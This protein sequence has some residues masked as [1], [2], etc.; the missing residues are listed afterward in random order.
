MNILYED[1]DVVVI[2][3][4][5]GVLV[6]PDG[7][8]DEEAVSDWFVRTYPQAREVGEPLTLSNGEVVARPGVVHRLDGDTSGVLVLAKTPEA[9]AH[10][11]EQFQERLVTKMYHAI[12]YGIPKEREGVITAPIGRSAK[13]FKLRSAQRGARGA[14]REAETRYEYDS[15]EGEFGLV[16]LFPKTGRTH[17]LRVHLKYIHHPIVCD[18]LYAPGKPCALGMNRLALHA[19]TISFKNRE[20]NVVE[21]TAPFPEDFASAVSQL[22]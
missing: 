3:K 8:T 7:H 13:N 17:Q 1:S 12:T 16:R 14:L 22:A 10:L 20:G 9:H 11:K 2:D 21:V 6:H 4:P 15:V 19:S 18:P 5:V